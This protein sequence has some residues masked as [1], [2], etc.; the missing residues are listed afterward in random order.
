MEINR[1]MRF[2][3]QGWNLA[4][5]G[6]RLTASRIN[7][8]GQQSTPLRTISEE[9]SAPQAVTP[10]PPEDRVTLSDEAR[11]LLEDQK[12]NTDKSTASA[13]KTAA[14]NQAQNTAAIRTSAQTAETIPGNYTA[15]TP[16][17]GVTNGS[18]QAAEGSIT[19]V[20]EQGRQDVTID[21]DTT[22]IAVAVLQSSMPP[23]KT[24]APS[25]DAPPPAA[26]TA[27]TAATTV[28]PQTVLSAYS[29]AATASSTVV[30]RVA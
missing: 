12:T 16:F 24:A 15:F 7:A 22:S 3:H 5:I 11:V 9:V 23:V 1:L 27:E 19:S 26:D 4:D 18:T 30:D 20:S 2:S 10:P 25:D 8:T 14:H 6:V 13:E 28:L 21:A 29:A 17:D